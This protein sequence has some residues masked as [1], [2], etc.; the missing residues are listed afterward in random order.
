VLQG[1]LVVERM[2]FVVL[3]LVMRV[4]QSPTKRLAVFNT[5]ATAAMLAVHAAAIPCRLAM[6]VLGVLWANTLLTLVLVVV[7]GVLAVLAEMSGGFWAF[8]LNMYNT[9]VG[10]TLQNEWIQPLA[11]G[12]LLLGGLLPLWNLLVY[13]PQVLL[14][15]VFLPAV[16][17]EPTHLR[18]MAG[19]SLLMTSA[20]AISASSSAQRILQCASWDVTASTA[21]GLVCI[22][23]SSYMHVDLMTPGIYA[24]R[25]LLTMEK[26]LVAGCNGGNLVL[27]MVMYPLLDFNLYKAVHCLVN[28]VVH[29]VI[30]MPITT[31]QRCLYAQVKSAD[32][33][34]SE[35]MIMCMPDFSMSC[36]VVVGMVRALAQLLQ[37]W[38]DA[39]LIV[40]ERGMGLESALCQTDLS[41]KT[42]NTMW[43]IGQGV[44]GRPQTVVPLTATL[45]AVTDGESTVYSSLAAADTWHAVGNWPLKV[46]VRAGVAPV[47]HSREMDAD[48]A[49]SV[50]TGMLGCA[51]VDVL[52]DNVPAVRIQCATVPFRNT[53]LVDFNETTLVQ[54]L[55]YPRGAELLLTCGT[56]RLQVLPLRF[57]RRRLSSNFN[58]AD[59][60]DQNAW[61][62]L[63]AIGQNGPREPE[64]YAADAAIFVQPECVGSGAG[65]GACVGEVS[66]FPFCMG[67]HIAGQNAEA[68]TLY[69]AR[70]WQESVS[71]AQMDCVSM[72]PLSGGSG[73]SGGSDASDTEY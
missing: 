39:A 48:D 11:W 64:L 58:G 36:S 28:A 41:A 13:L 1:V 22:A 34:M 62:T 17:L 23:D 33:A 12:E 54:T 71:V 40:V 30:A 16:S 45:V 20:L 72:A 66:C 60:S 44:L 9:G 51:C 18:E 19:D 53:D 25:L 56:I 61:R 65:I 70:S 49:A 31:V 5:I 32:F 14:R 55:F 4:P 10:A 26:V 68:I 42:I 47:R 59:G 29:T 57:S 67:L 63:D 69:N 46:D 24:R 73:C 15:Y 52:V 35:R 21:A 50:R 43:G 2:L 27:A 3:C 6:R 7:I 8:L 38:V 37:N